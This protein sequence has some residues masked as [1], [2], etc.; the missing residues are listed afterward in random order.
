[1]RR[2]FRRFF[3]HPRP[4]SRR[5]RGELLEVVDEG[6]NNNHPLSPR[7]R[8]AGRPGEGGLCIM[9]FGMEI[10]PQRGRWGQRI[11]HSL[12]VASNT[13]RIVASDRSN[14]RGVSSNGTAP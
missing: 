11:R 12:S 5:A 10:H 6:V 1:M 13:V 3:P 14:E 4:L 9:Y 2:T 7:E 8:G